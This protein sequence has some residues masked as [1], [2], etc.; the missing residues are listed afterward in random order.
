M[1]H[2][3][4]YK[5]SLLMSAFVSLALGFAPGL[6]SAQQLQITDFV[7]FSGNGGTGTTNPGS[8]GYGVIFGSS[9]T[10]N[11]G[12][13]GSY[14]LVKTTGNSNISANIF[15]KGKVILAN[16]NT[17]S[18]RITAA[19]SA[20]VS[21]TILQVGSNANLTGVI[22]VNGNIT[23]GG[24]S[25]SGPVTTSGTYSGPTPSNGITYGNPS[26]PTMPTLPSITSFPAAGSTNTT[27]TQ[28]ISPGPYG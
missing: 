13:I 24:G 26:L 5:R 28:T 7:M 16:G 27:T 25:V 19:N 14:A 10:I 9:T 12:A 2:A 3:N 15:S 22:D 8:S 21:G 6:V 23:V 18:G 11:N 1:Q 4:Y 17:V 20:G